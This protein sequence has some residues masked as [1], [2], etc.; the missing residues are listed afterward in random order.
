ML[1]LLWMLDVDVWNFVA[2]LRYTLH[3]TSLKLTSSFDGGQR[4]TDWK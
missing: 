2:A 1:E 4:G 3:A